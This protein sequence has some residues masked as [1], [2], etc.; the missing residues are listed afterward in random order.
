[1]SLRPGHGTAVTLL[2]GQVDTIVHLDSPNPRALLDELGPLHEIQMVGIDLSE[3]L[4]VAVVDGTADPVVMVRITPRPA[5]DRV[6]AGHPSPRVE[7]LIAHR[8]TVRGGHDLYG[9]D[10]AEL[11]VSAATALCDRP[12]M[13]SAKGIAVL[14]TGS[15]AQ[16]RHER[17]V[18]DLLQFAFP[19]THIS[20]AGDFGGLGLAPREA[21]VVLDAALSGVAGRLA[22]ELLDATARLPDVP[23]MIGRGDGGL[24]TLTGLRTHPVSVLQSAP[25]LRVLAAAHRS[26]HTDCRVVLT[27]GHPA[28]DPVGVPFIGEVRSGLVSAQPY[29]TTA[30]AADLVIPTA[31]LAPFAGYVDDDDVGS[32]PLVINGD[33]PDELAAAGAALS[34]PAAW[35]DE[36]AQIE[37]Q[38]Q[39]DR[40][41]QA[42]KERAVAIAI[43]NGTA[44]GTAEFVDVS[45]VAVPYSPSGTVRLRVRVAGRHRDAG[46]ERR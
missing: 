32:T 36:I 41:R 1:M 34:R 26:G 10:L 43:A 3:L 33:D 24:T 5:I 14:A 12:E 44:P 35:L 20:I 31:Q 42:A 15:A 40:I 21:T 27:L 46:R 25:A 37:D 45:T 23:V 39:L 6:L 13:A 38:D 9:R 19:E 17:D 11:D 28:S 18:A 29:L 4:G 2:D 30:L 8:F 16:S 7:H 22:G